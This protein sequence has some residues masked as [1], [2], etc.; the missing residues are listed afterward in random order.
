MN[1]T[2]QF[3]IKLKLKKR[4]SQNLKENPIKV[5]N[6]LGFKDFFVLGWLHHTWI[7]LLF[8]SANGISCTDILR[9]KNLKLLGLKISSYN[10][11]NLKETF[12]ASFYTQLAWLSDK[13]K[14]PWQLQWAWVVSVSQTIALFE[15]TEVW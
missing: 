13:L 5:Q 14:S 12:I 2:L 3:L 8:S 10:V 11:I 7:E 15:D 4:F 6:S 1:E 9:E